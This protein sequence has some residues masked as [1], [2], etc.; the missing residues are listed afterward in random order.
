MFL[1]LHMLLVFTEEQV[2]AE[3]CRLLR[4]VY[5][6]KVFIYISV[7]S[8]F[9]FSDLFRC[10]E[11]FL[12]CLLLCTVWSECNFTW[13][14]LWY[15]MW[16]DTIWWNDIRYDMIYDKMIYMIC[17]YDIYDIRYDIW[18][19]MMIWY[20]W[21]DIWYDIWYVIWYDIRWYMIWWYDFFLFI[22]SM[23]RYF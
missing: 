6:I 12:V 19:D 7:P 18:Y 3:C 21:F 17:R 11:P 14:M 9:I 10:S 22:Y 4:S 16:Y 23:P 2:A 5:R 13:Y 15:G 1:C 8:I 20:I